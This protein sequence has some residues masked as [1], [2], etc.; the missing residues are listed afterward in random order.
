MLITSNL[1]LYTAAF[2]ASCGHFV[3]KF[4]SGCLQEVMFGIPYSYCKVNYS[5]TTSPNNFKIIPEDFLPD[6][7]S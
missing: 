4:Y 6:A 2:I 1:F 5:K 7:T 3:S